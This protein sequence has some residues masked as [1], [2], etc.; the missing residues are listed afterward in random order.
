MRSREVGHDGRALYY[1]TLSINV[2]QLWHEYD[3]NMF[4]AVLRALAS[5]TI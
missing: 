5:V 1:L 2:A 3:A 4:V